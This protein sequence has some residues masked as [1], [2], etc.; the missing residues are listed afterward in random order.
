MFDGDSFTP[1]TDSYGT[2]TWFMRERAGT[3]SPIWAYMDPAFVL[4]V[5][6]QGNTI[7]EKFTLLGNYPNPFNPS[8]TIR[9]SLPQTSDVTLE[10]FNV[11]G[12]L[13]ATQKLG[14]QQPGVRSV[15][16]NAS[17]LATG[18]YTYRLQMASTNDVV[19]GKM[20]LLK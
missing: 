7:P 4:A 10:V 5:D 18:M 12:Q 9:F 11:L 20:M 6:D 17:S 2:R 14:E 1:I 13:V 3:D 15:Q 19:V 16:F 8:T